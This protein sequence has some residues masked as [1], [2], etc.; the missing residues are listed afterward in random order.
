MCVCVGS[1]GVGPY[2]CELRRRRQR[3]KPNAAAARRPTTPT[4]TPAIQTLLDSFAEGAAVGELV[5]VEVCEATL[6]PVEAGLA[7]VPEFE[8]LSRGLSV[9]VASHKGPG[10]TSR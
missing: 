4:T 2:A 5:E 7:V 6:V 1:C 8:E 10:G 9:E 3:K